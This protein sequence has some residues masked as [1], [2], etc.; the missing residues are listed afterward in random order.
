MLKMEKGLGMEEEPTVCTSV[1][2]KA[3]RGWEA[4]GREEPT[5]AYFFENTINL[6]RS[7]S[8]KY[9]L[10][11]THC[12]MCKELHIFEG[13]IRRLEI[14]VRSINL[15]NYFFEKLFDGPRNARK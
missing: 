7:R 3:G 9:K 14:R 4:E 1:R 2:G 12:V 15:L 11:V 5:P 8:M 13:K 6:P 10:D